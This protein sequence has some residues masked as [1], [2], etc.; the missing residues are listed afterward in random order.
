[1]INAK[2]SLN[3]QQLK[4]IE[5]CIR[6][7]DENR[8]RDCARGDRYWSLRSSQDLSSVFLG[9]LALVVAALARTWTTTAWSVEADFSLLVQVI[10][11]VTGFWLAYWSEVSPNL[12]ALCCFQSEVHAEM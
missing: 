1:M 12:Y 11:V 9:F 10:L 7:G 2:K 3:T 6:G 8:S 4:S 5:D